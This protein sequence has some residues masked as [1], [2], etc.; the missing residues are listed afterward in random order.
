MIGTSANYSPRVFVVWFD[1]DHISD[2]EDETFVRDVLGRRLDDD[3]YFIY[4]ALDEKC[5]SFGL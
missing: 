4:I 1:V 2:G 5:D 3:D